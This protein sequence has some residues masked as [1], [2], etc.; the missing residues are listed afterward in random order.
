[1]CGIF[2]II[3]KQSTE[4]NTTDLLN[5][6][7]IIRHRGPD[8]EGYL[9]YSQ[10]KEY[11]LYF[12]SDTSQESVNKYELERLPS[13]TSW[14]V[15]FGHRRLSIIDLSSE[16]FQPMARGH[17]SVCYNGE[18]YN[19]KELK[20]ELKALGHS[21]SSGSDTEVLLK[22]WEV[23]G[24]KAL[25]KFN[26]MFAFLLLDSKENIVY[27]VRDRFG[28]K[29]LYYAVIGESIVFASEIKQIKA[30]KKY[31]SSLNDNII[32]DYLTSGLVDHTVNTFD[33]NI[34][35]VKG[36]GLIK[37]HLTN[38]LSSI[39]KRIWYTIPQSQFSGS[40]E[41]AS[42]SF[43]ELFKDS[44]RLRLRSDV[45]VGSCLSGGFD[46]SAIV[47]QMAQIDGENNTK[48]NIETVTSRYSESKYDEWYYAKTVIDQTKSKSHSV[49]PSFDQLIEELDKLMWHMDEPFGS[50]SQFSQWCVF[51]GAANAGLKVM[52]DGQGADEQLAGYGGNDVALYS[53]L[54]KK[55]KFGSV[56]KNFKGFTA[57]FGYPPKSQLIKGVVTTY[58]ILGKILPK[59]KNSP[60][61]WIK[62]DSKRLRRGCSLSLREEMILQM[63][64]TSLPA[65]L[66]YEDR[67]S[68][69]F[70]IESRVPFLDYRLV[71]LVLSMPEEY[72]YHLGL[73]KVLLRH[74]LKHLLPQDVI[75]RKDKM[76]FVSP[77]ELWFKDKENTWFKNELSKLNPELN[78]YVDPGLLAKQIDERHIGS[79]NFDFMPWRILCFNRWLAKSTLKN[80]RFN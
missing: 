80:N 70:S 64:S 29:P 27:A 75:N 11:K 49:W 13:S 54:I 34:N 79:I 35:Q 20:S 23:W 40:L 30:L 3:H 50:T 42:E 7:K 39:D 62:A 5:S 67:N 2:G 12:D 69:A 65:L 17:L 14:Q 77:E 26:G 71:E 76:G 52:L 74:S 59:T 51:Q 72:I 9:L 73:R 28:V 18:I 19:Y 10:N 61:D 58:P 6:T 56:Y 60:F 4:H 68:M 31:Q 66:R 22:S 32:I 57:E 37:V 21:F 47:C 78:Q 44:V 24:E 8:D 43:R 53:G 15:G 33:T 16:G 41:E 36:G 63:T 25:N 38:P 45:K 1:M 46:S 55:F 48:N